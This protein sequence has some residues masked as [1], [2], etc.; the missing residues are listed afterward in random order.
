[1]AKTEL[2]ASSTKND[3]FMEVLNL[4]ARNNAL[5][6]NEASLHETIADLRLRNRQ[7]TAQ[8]LNKPTKPEPQ[9]FFN[10]L[11]KKVDNLFGG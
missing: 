9:G 8:K 2:T 6:I 11:K 3:L 4:R 7:L 10:S 5:A 1:M